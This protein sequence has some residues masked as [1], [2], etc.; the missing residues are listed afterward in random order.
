DYYCA[1]WDDR[2]SSRLF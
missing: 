1:A 2:L